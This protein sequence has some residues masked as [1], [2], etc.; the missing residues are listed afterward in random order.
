[1]IAATV[2]AD[3]H[4]S[5]RNANDHRASRRRRSVVPEDRLHSSLPAPQCELCSGCSISGTRRLRNVVVV[6]T[7]IRLIEQWARFNVSTTRLSGRQFYRSKD[8]T[9]S[10]IKV[11][12]EHKNR[13]IAQTYRKHSKSLVCT[14]W[15]DYRGWLPQRNVSRWGTVVKRWSVAHQDC[16]W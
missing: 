2:S 12:K 15:G 4:S 3:Q 11:L 5:N 1:M 13:M 14:I 9:N 6:V 8:P 7:V 10:N 16:G